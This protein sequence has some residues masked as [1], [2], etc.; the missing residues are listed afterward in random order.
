MGG[1]LFLFLLLWVSR[2]G[3]ETKVPMGVSC[4]LFLVQ[5]KGT[6]AH[7]DMTPESMAAAVDSPGEG[8]SL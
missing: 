1:G 3:V 6:G 7:G 5:D 8:W 2:C 4:S